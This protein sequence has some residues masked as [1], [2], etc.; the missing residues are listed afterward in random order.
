MTRRRR[1]ETSKCASRRLPARP[2]AR[3]GAQ[4]L[5]NYLSRQQG[6]LAWARLLAALQCPFPLPPQLHGVTR[7]K[8][9]QMLAA[10][11]LHSR[12]IL[13]TLSLLQLPDDFHPR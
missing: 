7:R 5:E 2:P 6:E 8:R 4:G 12:R 3:T 10:R 13:Y 9:R 1:R 11:P